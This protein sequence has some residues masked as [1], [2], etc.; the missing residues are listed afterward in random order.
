LVTAANGD[1]VKP[2]IRIPVAPKRIPMSVKPS[3]AAS[4][5]SLAGTS[6]RISTRNSPNHARRPA[7]SAASSLCGATPGMRFP[8]KSSPPTEKLAKRAST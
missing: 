6:S 1:S 3:A 8:S 5:A 4:L 2:P 7:R